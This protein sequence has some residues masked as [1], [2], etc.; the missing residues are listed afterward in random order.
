MSGEVGR[1]KRIPFDR[2]EPGDVVFF[3]A[4]AARAKPAEVDHMGIYVG[5]G[6]MVHASRDGVALSPLA[7]WYRDRFAWGRRPLAEAVLN[8]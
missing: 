3:G 8:Q 6:W 4:K 5:S 7:G 1:A 2:L